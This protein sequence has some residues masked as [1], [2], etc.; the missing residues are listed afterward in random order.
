MGAIAAVASGM[1]A[2]AAVRRREP[3]IEGRLPA[4]ASA[5]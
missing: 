1:V 2:V 3:A 5:S 4:L